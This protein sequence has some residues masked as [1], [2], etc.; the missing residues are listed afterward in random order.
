M[1][2]K[3][4]DRDSDSIKPFGL[5]CSVSNSFWDLYL[6]FEVILARNV[7]MWA[8]PKLAAVL[9][10]VTRPEDQESY[11]IVSCFKCKDFGDYHSENKRFKFCMEEIFHFLNIIDIIT[12]VLIE[13][14]FKFLRTDDIYCLWSDGFVTFCLLIDCTQFYLWFYS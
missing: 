11:Y 5:F 14:I 9:L 12:L 1:L 6:H 3:V 4:Y 10:E 2:L 13:K 8:I 7:T